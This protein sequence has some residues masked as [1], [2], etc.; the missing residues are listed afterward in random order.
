MS[1]S[2]RRRPR[3]PAFLSAVPPRRIQVLFGDAHGAPSPLFGQ[4]GDDEELGVES[5]APPLP[6]PAVPLQPEERDR[7]AGAVEELRRA[8]ARFGEALAANALE[9]GC[10][11]A[12]RILDAEL[13]SDPEL[14]LAL[15]RSAVRRLGEAQKVVVH[16]SPTDRDAVAEAMGRAGAADGEPSDAT[17]VAPVGIPLARIELVSDTNL[18]PGDTLVESDTAIVDGR[19]GTRLEELRRVL[20][21]VV[22]SASGDRS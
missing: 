9:I 11:L 12:R 22:N 18:S 4:D 2:P 20:S 17:A 16:L 7:V 19:L 13:K 1:G 15:V 21:N 8:S 6:A 3:S 5:L 14:R 10:L